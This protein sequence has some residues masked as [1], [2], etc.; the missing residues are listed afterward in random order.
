MKRKQKQLFTIILALLFCLGALQTVTFAANSEDSSMF[1]ATV[2]DS[3]E[4]RTDD[5]SFENEAYNSDIANS[6]QNCSDEN[7]I[8]GQ[9]FNKILMKSTDTSN[10]FFEGESLESG[11][12]RDVERYTVLVLDTSSSS[13]FLNGENLIY[14]ADTALDYVKKSAKKFLEDI[15]DADGTNYVAIV[16]YK[17]IATV[18]SDFSTDTE[19][20]AT[21]VDALSSADVIRDM[22]SG[23]DTANELLATVDNPSARKTVVLFTTGMTNNGAYTYSG[24]YDEDTIGSRWY[25]SD[26]DIRLYAYANTAYNSV[27]NLKDQGISV[28]TIGLFQ[29][30]EGM[31]D[32]GKDIVEFFKLT[33]FDLATSEDYYYPVDDPNDLEFVFGEVA[34]DIIQDKLKKLYTDQHIE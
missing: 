8:Q 4:V 1:T 6:A 15:I 24:H 32:E 16:S 31:P 7:Q 14:T 10:A 27:Q 34:D 13:D 9:A 18:I 29:T 17:S 26:T 28:Y 30:M 3:T 12:P 22:S 25:R 19:M 33:T 11:V 2:I 20:L 23:L 5:D 21:K